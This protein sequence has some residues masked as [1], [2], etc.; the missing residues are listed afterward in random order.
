VAERVARTWRTDEELLSAIAANDPAAFT[1]FYRR[2]L[3][4]T[5]AYLMRHTRDP[6]L[7]A[8]AAAEVFAGVL[9]GAHRYRDEAFSAGP[10]VI[11]LARNKLQLSLR[12]GRIEA[13]D[14][15]RLGF[16]PLALQDADLERVAGMADEGAGSLSA[17][18]DGLPDQERHVVLSPVVQEQ[19]HRQVATE[20]RCSEMVVRKRASRGLSRIRDRLARS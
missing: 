16:E 14:R 12:Q 20:L 19:G 10:W 9:L 5:L 8:D 7:A 18:V 17:M 15:K 2:H 1:Q 11:G 13:Q 4:M 6:E 3:P